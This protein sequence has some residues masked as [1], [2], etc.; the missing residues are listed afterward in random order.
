MGM[1]FHRF[2]IHGQY[3]KAWILKVGQTVKIYTK[4]TQTLRHTHTKHIPK[5]VA[6]QHPENVSLA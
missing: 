5:Y 1:E 3:T 6:A 2:T 4:H